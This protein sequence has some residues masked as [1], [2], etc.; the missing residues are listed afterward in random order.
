MI[1]SFSICRNTI[2]FEVAKYYSLLFRRKAAEPSPNDYVSIIFGT[3]LYKK[4]KKKLSQM[5]QKA[6]STSMQQVVD[7]GDS[8]AQ[9][10][11]GAPTV[12]FDPNNMGG[13]PGGNAGAN[14]GNNPNDNVTDIDYEEVK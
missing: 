2:F 13:N 6:A 9:Q 11:L 7:S 12:G 8:F 1:V 14:Q 10:A 3:W 5:V 4:D